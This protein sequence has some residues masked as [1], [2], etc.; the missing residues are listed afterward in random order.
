M[1]FKILYHEAVVSQDIP[2]ISKEWRIKIKRGIEDKLISHPEVFGKPLRNSL[3][4]YR[5]LRVGD[6]RI[7]F[8]IEEN[9]IKVLAIKHR[10]VVYETTKK[11]V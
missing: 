6:Y 9:I 3:K 4:G 5:K 10:S 11:R 1:S 7:V 8:R 2:R